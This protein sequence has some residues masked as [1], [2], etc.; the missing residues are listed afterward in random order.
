MGRFARPIVLCYFLLKKV[1][2]FFVTFLQES[3]RIEWPVSF[4]YESYY[5]VVRRIVRVYTHAYAPSKGKARA[6]APQAIDG[7]KE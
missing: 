4:Y 7:L 5:V 1:I 2:V 3:Y 6:G